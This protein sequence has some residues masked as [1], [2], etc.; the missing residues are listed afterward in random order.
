MSFQYESQKRAKEIRGSKLSYRL[1]RSQLSERRRKESSR[2]LNTVIDD[3]ML[4]NVS[5]IKVF[6]IKLDTLWWDD[7]QLDLQSTYADQSTLHFQISTA[8]SGSWSG[9]QVMP[10]RCIT[11][12]EMA[13]DD[14]PIGQRDYDYDGL[15]YTRTNPLIQNDTIDPSVTEL[16]RL[17]AA[18]LLATPLD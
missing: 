18:L 17:G 4:A 1:R 2:E 9:E 16:R 6:N 12:T 10:N 14:S 5:L 15:V 13:P 3:L 7:A 11:V 8:N